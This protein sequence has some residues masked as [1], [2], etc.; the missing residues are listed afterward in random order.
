M[1]N[2]EQQL[3]SFEVA[4]PVT[5]TVCS[6]LPVACK[7]QSAMNEEMVAQL[8]R[9]NR[10]QRQYDVLRAAYLSALVC[11][12]AG[13]PS[14]SAF[15]DEAGTLRKNGSKCNKEIIA[16]WQSDGELR[17]QASVN[18]LL[19]EIARLHEENS[20]KTEQIDA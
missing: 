17:T 6:P 16:A 18:R 15:I 13:K 2:L 14:E 4:A 3:P 10:L 8:D 12:S 7:G 5:G 9:L 1:R 20:V 19:E 11:P